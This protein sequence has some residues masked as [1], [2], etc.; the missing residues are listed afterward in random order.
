MLKK[1][2]ELK[3]SARELK[4]FLQSNVYWDISRDLLKR[5]A[6]LRKVIYE[7]VQLTEDK[8]CVSDERIRGRI[9]TIEYLSTLMEDLIYEAEE[10]EKI[11]KKDEKEIE[12]A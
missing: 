2:F 9:D 1:P 4:D 8:F 10:A 5:R 3:S 12:N 7:G 11:A 6:S